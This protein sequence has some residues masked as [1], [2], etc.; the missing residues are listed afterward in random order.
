MSDQVAD[1]WAAQGSLSEGGEKDDF[2]G[3]A[4]S[5]AYRTAAAAGQ[6]RSSAGAAGDRACAIIGPPA[7][8]RAGTPRF[9]GADQNDRGAAAGDR[10]A[11]CSTESQDARGRNAAGGTEPDQA[12]DP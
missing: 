5:G 11:F 4:A 8:T 9:G 2:R 3:T 6:N 7:A 1:S 12:G 10:A